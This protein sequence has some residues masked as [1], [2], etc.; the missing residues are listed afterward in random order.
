M[1]SKLYK[2][3]DQVLFWKNAKDRNGDPI[4]DDATGTYS[5]ISRHRVNED[6][7]FDADGEF[8]ELAAGSLEWVSAGRFEAVLDADVTADVIIG[9]FYTIELILA[10]PDGNDGRKVLVVEGADQT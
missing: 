1:A 7:E 4:A 3:C 2:S 9:M 8:Q 5:I 10:D 6:G